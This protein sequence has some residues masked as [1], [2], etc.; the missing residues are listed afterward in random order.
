MK[1]RK[2]QNFAECAVNFLLFRFFWPFF[3]FFYENFF[4]S[5]TSGRTRT[6]FK[7]GDIAFLSVVL[8]PLI[9]QKSSI[10]VDENLEIMKIKAM[11]QTEYDDFIKKLVS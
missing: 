5:I 8:A 2:I 9:G 11:K 10:H 4:A 1:S 7:K 6:D 3:W